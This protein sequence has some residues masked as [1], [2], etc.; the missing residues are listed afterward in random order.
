MSY[1]NP[2]FRVDGQDGPKVYAANVGIGLPIIN[3][4]SNRSMV[5]IALEYQRVEPSVSHSIREQ[6][7]NLKLG[8]MFNAKWFSK[9]KFE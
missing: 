1:T 9:W 8:L 6:Y 2:Y 4:Y 7:F 5:N 3:K